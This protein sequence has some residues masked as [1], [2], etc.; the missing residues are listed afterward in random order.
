M[1]VR[2]DIGIAS[3]NHRIIKNVELNATQQRIIDL[4][5]EDVQMSG[6]ELATLIGISKRNVETNIKNSRKKVY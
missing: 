6:T 3:V 1:K 4:L 5:S 2:Q